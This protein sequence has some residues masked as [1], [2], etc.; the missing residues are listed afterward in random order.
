MSR[1]KKKLIGNQKVLDK[2]KNG[3]LDSQDFK[4]LRTT[5]ESYSN[6]RDEL[7]EVVE[8]IS[9]K[10]S[11]KIT[12]HKVNNLIKI[13]PNS[14]DSTDRQNT[15]SGLEESVKSLGGILLE[16]EEYSIPEILDEVTNLDLLLIDSD[17]LENLVYDFMIESLEDGYSIEEIQSYVFESIDYSLSLLSEDGEDNSRKTQVLREIK[18]FIKKA[19]KKIARSVGY[20]AGAGVRAAK[21]IGREVGG[22]YQRGR[23]GSGHQEHDDDDDDYEPVRYVRVPRR[24]RVSASVSDGLRSTVARRAGYATGAAV[25]GARNLGREFR[26]GY[27]AGRRGGETVSSSPAPARTPRPYSATYRRGERVDVAGK[28]EGQKL[29]PAAKQAKRQPKPYSATYG[30]GKK[31]EVT[32]TSEPVSSDKPKLLSP[33]KEPQGKGKAKRTR[34]SAQPSQSPRSRRRTRAQQADEL[35]RQIRSTNESTT[36]SENLVEKITKNTDIG[37]AIRDFYVSDDSRLKGR[38]KRQRRNAAIAAVLTARRGGR[39]L[40]EATST[41]LNPTTSKPTEAQ[42]EKPNPQVMRNLQNINNAEMQ[43][44]RKKLQLQKQGKLPLTHTG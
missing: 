3:M 27:S 5:K 33:A 42:Q 38:S 8:H 31:V 23:Y 12:G 4:I 13:N 37:D 14:Q 22:G 35:I 21:G 6:W 9:S 19:V 29:L 1:R 20:V 32:G 30:G 15:N 44:Q 11:R 43:L 34:V 2:N 36:Q 18:E 40:K 10:N 7:P 24:E 26:S 25:R 16:M 28:P 39:K 41:P 17:L